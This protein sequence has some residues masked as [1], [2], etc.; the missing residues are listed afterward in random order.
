M[1]TLIAVYNSQG[2][3]G[4]CDAKCYMATGPECDC[5]CGGKNHGAGL[6][7]AVENTRELAE[8]WLERYTK[9]K[10]L[11]SWRSEIPALEPV[12]LSLF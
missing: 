2:L 1:T 5:I 4:R 8:S 12:Q 9:E 3:V 6:E 10:K 7:K 11:E